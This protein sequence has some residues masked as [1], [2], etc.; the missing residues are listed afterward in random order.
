[1]IPMN[2]IL[3][4][5]YRIHDAQNQFN[6]L[7]MCRNNEKYIALLCKTLNNFYSMPTHPWN[8][9]IEQRPPNL[10]TL[11]IHSD[12]LDCIICYDRAEQYS[13]AESLAHSLHIPIILVDMCSESLIRPQHLLEGL[14]AQDPA[15]LYRKPHL[16]I[17]NSDHIQNSWNKD[18]VSIVVPIGID[19]DTLQKHDIPETLVSLD[20]NVTAQLGAEISSRI[21]NAYPLIPTD[22]E[23]GQPKSL[24]RTR[25]FINTNQTITVKM[26][27]AMSCENVV[28]TIRNIDTENFI[29]H[30]KTGILINNL[31]DILPAINNLEKNQAMRLQIGKDARKKIVNDH[32][33]EK[34]TT[35]W[36][37]AFSFLKSNFYTPHS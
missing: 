22:I 13:E 3:R 37:A 31:D 27:E 8:E 25:Y 23:V 33:L 32:S 18:T 5:V 35:K 17:S 9:M 21:G 26:L 7:T 10:H 28:I 29:D 36:C 2:N 11:N 1:M 24:P 12:P 15:L 34:F 19:T 16:R 6:V 14:N 30:E 4:S 20:N